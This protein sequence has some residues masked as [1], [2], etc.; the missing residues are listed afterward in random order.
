MS[1]LDKLIKYVKHFLA[2]DY[3]P[4]EKKSSSKPKVKSKKVK[5]LT[6]KKKVAPKKKIKK[7]K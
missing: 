7:A 5:G 1:F 4:E 3:V 2:I 6:P